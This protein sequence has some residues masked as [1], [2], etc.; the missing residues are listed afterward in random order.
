MIP[1]ISIG[2]AR[3]ERERRIMMI[4][5][6]EREKNNDDGREREKLWEDKKRE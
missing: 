5:E 4:E 3:R 1:M 6:R 2:C